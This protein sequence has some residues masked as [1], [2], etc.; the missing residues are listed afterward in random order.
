M[1]RKRKFLR[2]AWF[3]HPRLGMKWRRPR[4]HQSKLRKGFKGHITKPSI[5]FSHPKEFRGLIKGFRTVNVNSL[6][7]VEMVQKGY[8]IIIAAGVGKRKALEIEKKANERGIKILN[9]K[10]I[11]KAKLH[12]KKIEKMKISKAEAE[13]QAKKK[14]AEKKEEPK[15]TE[16]PKP[17]PVD[18]PKA[19]PVTKKD[20]T[21]R[22]EIEG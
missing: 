6:K 8:A 11:R 17:K 5:G 20:E 4:G 18:K 21:T 19:A 22:K 10:K 12:V 16:A 3:K 2:Q 13:L 9:D 7:D 1:V 14:A 15:K